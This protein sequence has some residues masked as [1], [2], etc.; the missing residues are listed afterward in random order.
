MLWWGPGGTEDSTLPLQNGFWHPRRRGKPSARGLIVLVYAQPC[1][2]FYLAVALCSLLPNVSSGTSE[3]AEVIHLVL[4]FGLCPGFVDSA[5]KPG[6]ASA[7]PERTRYPVP[8]NSRY[9]LAGA[10]QSLPQPSILL[11]FPIDHREQ[12]F[13][14]LLGSRRRPALLFNWSQNETTTTKTPP[15]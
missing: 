10:S 12:H 2:L 9:L 7:Y 15:K 6:P 3:T 13:P 1:R 14:L 11:F 8:A 5:A 4:I